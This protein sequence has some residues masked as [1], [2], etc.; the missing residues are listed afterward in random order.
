MKKDIFNGKVLREFR[1][2]MWL[3]LVLVTVVFLLI[4]VSALVCG[5][6]EN[7]E[8]RI[9]LFCISG[10]CFLIAVCLPIVM[11]HLIRIYPRCKKLTRFLVKE[12]VFREYDGEN[13]KKKY[14]DF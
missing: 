14:E 1:S 10:V 4:G 5:F 7:G 9:A 11:V 13:E 6:L 3:L 2:L 12:F 8:G